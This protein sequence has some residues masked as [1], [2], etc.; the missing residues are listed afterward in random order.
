[1]K[2]VRA[3]EYL[4]VAAE[5]T[6]SVANGDPLAID[7]TSILGD[8]ET[9]DEVESITPVPTGITLANA[10]PNDSEYE[11]GGITVAIGKGVLF[12]KSGGTKGRS[13]LV[14][15]VVTLSTESQRGI[16]FRIVVE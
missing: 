11:Q 15:M 6:Y 8:S 14:R 12:D 10:A 16:E 1:M 5:D 9:I 3:R 4:Q 7:L 2:F 13:Y